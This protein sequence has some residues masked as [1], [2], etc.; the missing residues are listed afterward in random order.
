MATITTQKE[1]Y[2]CDDIKKNILSYLCPKPMR[3]TNIL[4]PKIKKLIFRWWVK[5]DEEQERSIFLK[6]R[7]IV[8][9]E[10]ALYEVSSTGI[11]HRAKEEAILSNNSEYMKYLRSY[12]TILYALILSSLSHLEEEKFSLY[13]V[14]D[15]KEI[16][17]LEIKEKNN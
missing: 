16:H 12:K 15:Y 7:M 1:F 8:S 6:F 14:E 2:F 13:G 3:L 17:L 5:N 10:Q 9:R 11:N 4:D